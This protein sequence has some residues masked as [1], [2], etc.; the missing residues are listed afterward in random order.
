LLGN[1]YAGLETECGWVVSA[2]CI[3]LLGTAMWSLNSSKA[4]IHFQ[5]WAYVPVVLLF[6]VFGLLIFDLRQFNE[7]LKFGL[8]TAAAPL[9]IFMIDALHGLYFEMKAGSA[10]TDRG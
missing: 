1:K 8:L 2:G 3:T 9:A 4:W 7:V 6:Q 5:A 10:A